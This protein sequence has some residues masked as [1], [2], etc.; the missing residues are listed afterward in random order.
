MEKKNKEKLK[1]S[2]IK[3]GEKKGSGWWGREGGDFDRQEEG[4]ETNK[5]VQDSNKWQ[6]NKKGLEE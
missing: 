5:R 1:T 4:K 3:Q 6:K 2:T